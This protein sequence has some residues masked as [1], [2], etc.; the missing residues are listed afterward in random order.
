MVML[1]TVFLVA[2]VML[3]AWG[4]HPL[5]V[6]L[7]L[8]PF[9]FIEGV[10]LSANILNIPHGGWFSITLAGVWPTRQSHSRQQYEQTDKSKVNHAGPAHSWTMYVLSIKMS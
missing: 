5:L 6:L 2:L 7:F 1:S 4:T 9:T 10:F 8:A 3:V